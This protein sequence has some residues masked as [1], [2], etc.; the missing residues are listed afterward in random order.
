MAHVPKQQIPEGMCI[1]AKSVSDVR[2]EV[3]YN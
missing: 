1:A 3:T 2:E